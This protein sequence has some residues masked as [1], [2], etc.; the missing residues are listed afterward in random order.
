MK[1]LIINFTPTGMIP[2]K[3]MT[4]FVPITPNE[5]IEQ[6]HEAFD[7][8]I[9]MV[10]LH[11]RDSKT[12]QPTHKM[13]EYS[14]ILEG[15][16]RH[17]KS[18]VTCLSLSGRSVNEFEQR[19]E[20]LELMPDMASLTLSS[21][22]FTKQPSVNSPEM[23]GL[24]AKK[25]KEYGVKPELEIFDIGMINYGDYLIKKGII[26]AP[27][28]YNIILGNISGLQIDFSH[29]GTAVNSLPNGSIWSLGGIGNS[30]LPAATFAIAGG[31][32]VRIGLEDN[33]YFNKSRTKKAT[34]IELIARVHTLA[35]MFEREV[36]TPKEFGD[37]GFYN[38]NR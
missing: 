6:V 22:N 2:T 32:G 37:K 12:E 29:I 28:Y 23:I 35:E 21:L 25:M 20:C 16:R 3:E 10:H 30:Q 38:K 33:I 15:V 4:P 19:S 17:C 18:L 8:G 1:K 26:A 7:L 14:L 34:N 5:I 24:L 36:M 9:T 31:G 27:L 11:A 13:E